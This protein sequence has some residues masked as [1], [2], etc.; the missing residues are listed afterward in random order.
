M[1]QTGRTLH[2]QSC[3]LKTYYICSQNSTYFDTASTQ[4][5]RNT[6]Y[7]TDVKIWNNATFILQLHR[8]KRY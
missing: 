3:Y 6:L 4:Y 1:T 7:C 8:I 5:V 2:L